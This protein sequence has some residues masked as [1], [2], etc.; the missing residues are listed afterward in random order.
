M[1]AIGSGGEYFLGKGE[2]ID[3]SRVCTGVTDEDKILCAL[4]TL[5]EEILEKLTQSGTNEFSTKV[6]YPTE[7]LLIG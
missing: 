4:E 1:I 7:K 2:S 3:K 6:P 5:A